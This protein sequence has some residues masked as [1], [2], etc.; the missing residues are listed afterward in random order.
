[1]GYTFALATSLKG[2]RFGNGHLHSLLF[3]QVL[4]VPVHLFHHRPVH[5]GGFDPDLQDD[6]LLLLRQAFSRC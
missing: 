6:I 4:P 5:I 3:Q 2:A 1:M